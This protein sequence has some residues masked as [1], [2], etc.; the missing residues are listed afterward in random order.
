MEIIERI[1]REAR[2]YLAEHGEL[3]IEHEPEQS[4]RIISLAQELGYETSETLPDQ[5]AVLRWSVFRTRA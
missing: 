1:L 4:E 5:Y 3:W 2:T